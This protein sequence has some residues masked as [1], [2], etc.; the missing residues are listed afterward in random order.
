MK[1][2]FRNPENDININKMGKCDKIG[3]K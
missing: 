2:E 3:G 1:N